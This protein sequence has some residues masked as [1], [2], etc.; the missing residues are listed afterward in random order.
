MEANLLKE[1][2]QITLDC[3]VVEN[4]CF[5]E[6]YTISLTSAH[7]LCEDELDHE[8]LANLSKRSA[9]DTLVTIYD[10][11]RLFC[12]GCIWTGTTIKRLELIDL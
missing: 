6:G 10:T 3:W 2:K 9:I 4:L 5:P 11:A 1:M 7:S 8:Y 12:T